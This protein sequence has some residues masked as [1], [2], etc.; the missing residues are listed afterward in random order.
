MQSSSAQAG[1]HSQLPHVVAR[2]VVT[3]DYDRQHRR[4]LLA[5]V[6]RVEGAQIAELVRDGERLEVVRVAQ[7]L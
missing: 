4:D 6:V 5:R 3:S 2:L 1:A 7:G